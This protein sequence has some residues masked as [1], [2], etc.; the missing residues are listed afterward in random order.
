MVVGPTGAGKSTIIEL[1]KDGRFKDDK[2]KVKIYVLN[3]KERSVS[4]L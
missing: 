2:T 4:D 1:L 3:P